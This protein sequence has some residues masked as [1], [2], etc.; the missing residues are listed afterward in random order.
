MVSRGRGGRGDGAFPLLELDRRDTL[1]CLGVGR[2]AGGGGSGG[3]VGLG[4]GV[5]EEHHV[6]QRSACKQQTTQMN[7]DGGENNMKRAKEGRETG[8]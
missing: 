6:S 5:G 2:G 7:N 4:Q 8:S 3:G 1:E